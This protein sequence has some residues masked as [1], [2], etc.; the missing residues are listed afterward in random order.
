M[1]DALAGLPD[2]ERMVMR[3]HLVGG[4][5]VEAIGK[6]YDVSQSTVSRWLA[7]ARETIVKTA[8]ALLHERL[9][10][11]PEEFQSLAA[12]VVSQLDLS[13]SRVLA[14]RAR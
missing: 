11:A 7:K 12:L 4:M 2:R 8:Q 10:V 5:S 6:M 14:S 13:L 1:Q 9:R 3:L